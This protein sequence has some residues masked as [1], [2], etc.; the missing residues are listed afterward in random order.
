MSDSGADL[1]RNV[2]KNRKINTMLKFSYKDALAIAVVLS[3][4]SPSGNYARVHSPSNPLKEAYLLQ[5]AGF[6]DLKL[7]T[8]E[9]RSTGLCFSCNFTDTYRSLLCV[10]EWE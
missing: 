5:M 2:S 8:S 3:I 10:E 1:V 7:S 9:V 4:H 6:P